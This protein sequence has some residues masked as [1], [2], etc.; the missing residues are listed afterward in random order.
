MLRV[1][2]EE[3]SLRERRENIMHRDRRYSDDFDENE[4]ELYQQYKEQN[5]VKTVP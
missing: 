1:R 4:M 5:M 3:F 2:D